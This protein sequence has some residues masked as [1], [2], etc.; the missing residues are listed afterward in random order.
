MENERKS[1]ESFRVVL[2][3]GTRP[4]AIKLAPVYHELA[5]VP[6]I[7]PV[8]LVTGQ[9]QEQL[10]QALDVFGI[11]AT[12]NLRV[13]TERQRLPELVQRILPE[14]ARHLR[15]IKADYVLVQGDTLSTFAIAWAAFLERI[16]VG[17][18]EA[19]LRTG[20]IEEPFP[21][22]ANRRLTA[23]LADMHFAPTPLARLNLIEEGVDSHHILVTGQTG[24]DALL[25]AMRKGRLP[26]GMRPGPYVTVTLHRRENWPRL[27]QLA[28][29]VRLTAERHPGHTYVFPLHRNP[30][31]REEVVPELAN[32]PNVVLT[33]PL[34]Y[35][36]MIALLSRS[37][38][39]L[40]DSGGLQEE[41][42]TLG[43]PVVVLRETTERP[44]GVGS[45]QLIV[46]G[47][48][49]DQVLASIETALGRRCV[50]RPAL[51]HNPY[52]DGRA[53][54][55]VARGVGWRLGLGGRPRDWKGAT[56]PK[57]ADQGSPTRRGAVPAP[58]PAQ[59][60]SR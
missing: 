58:V 9:H 20:L 8:I 50:R 44:E 60:R 11:R 31:V 16:P 19:G 39:V 30:L 4:E 46:A 24:V 15:E 26:A 53:S 49:P 25:R 18:V 37:D 54:N 45:G 29:I 52:G 42:T 2:G 34:D 43:V 28:R 57:S 17:H 5:A 32:L 12:A 59:R 33:D 55:R 22:E 56:Q 40:T 35:G 14:A 23:V 48:D 36:A 13:M 6:R 38:L 51:E 47:Y 1:E 27:R 7:D 3:F 21:E 41:G 10:D